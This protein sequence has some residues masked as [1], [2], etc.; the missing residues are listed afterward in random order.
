MAVAPVCPATAQLV[1]LGVHHGAHDPLGEAP[2]QLL[3][4][5]APSSKWGMASMS[6]V[7]SDKISVAVF[8]LSQNLLMWWFQIPGRRPLF[9]KRTLGRRPYTN[10]FDAIMITE[11]LLDWPFVR[12]SYLRAFSRPLQLAHLFR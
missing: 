2:E 5:V 10:I 12:M 11:L 4:V 9:V 6:S 8:V 3:H 7:G 1:S